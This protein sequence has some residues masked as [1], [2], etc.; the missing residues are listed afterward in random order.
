ML[1][2][3]SISG[4]MDDVASRFREYVRLDRLRR[5]D[6]LTPTELARWK[7]LKRILAQHFAP[8]LSDE[9]ADRR[10]SVRVPARLRV[11][12]ATDGALAECLLTNFSRKGVF[13]ETP[14]PAEIGTRFELRVLVSKPAHELT[15][16]VEVVSHGL[17]PRLDERAGMGLRILEV[18][19]DVE[20]QLDDLYARLVH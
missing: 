3:G 5:D 11:A 17:G 12:F 18:G 6:G 8:G 13:V 1:R 4:A 16:P 15:L 14:H 7:A 10:E 19:P 9:L 2:N 20:K